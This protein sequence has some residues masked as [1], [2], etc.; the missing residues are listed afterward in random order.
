MGD[1]LTDPS[2]F[3]VRQIGGFKSSEPFVVRLFEKDLFDEFLQ[4]V[5]IIPDSP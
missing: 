3:A 1:D 2:H 5:A 4:S